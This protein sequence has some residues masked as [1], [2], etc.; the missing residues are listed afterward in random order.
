M[1]SHEGQKKRPSLASRYSS[2]SV[3]FARTQNDELSTS[4]QKHRPQRHVVGQGRLGP[5]V[6]SYGKNVNKLQKLMQQRPLEVNGSPKS[7]QIKRNSSELHRNQEWSSTNLRKNHSETSL[8]KNRSSG[9]LN[10][11]ARPTAAK[12]SMKVSYKRPNRPH[13][14]SSTTIHVPQGPPNPTVRF[15]LGHEEEEEEE[16]GEEEDVDPHED[17]SWTNESAS[18][19]PCTSRSNTRPNSVN[20]SP[21]RSPNSSREVQGENTIKTQSHREDSC[22]PNTPLTL[23]SEASLTIS[24]KRSPR[25]A[26]PSNTNGITT[27][28]L[29]RNSS[30]TIAPQ[31]SNVSSTPVHSDV[32]S[33]QESSRSAGH[34]TLNDNSA[35]EIVSRFLN[36]GSSSGPHTSS[37]LPSHPETPRETSPVG[38][39]D[40]DGPWRNKPSPNITTQ[41]VSRTQR[42]LNLEREAIKNE[43]VN[44]ARP[45]ISILRS[46]HLSN[47]NIAFPAVRGSSDAHLRRLFEQTDI[48]YRR[49]HAFHNP[50]GDAISRLQETG[51][52][53]RARLVQK[54]K[55]GGKQGLL[56]SSTGAGGDGRLGL[57][58]SWRSERSAM[59]G[60]DETGK[61][62]RVSFQGIKG[63]KDD[64]ELEKTSHLEGDDRDKKHKT[65]Q[66]EVRELC[67]RLWTASWEHEQSESTV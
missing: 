46:S 29:N 36:P 21:R 18:Q 64:G 25:R 4:A 17:A 43:P 27:R 14:S 48:E 28:L 16:P 47:V 59:R 62:Q 56:A 19:S 51:T 60:N 49:M 7:S 5:R 24:P 8:K 6:P 32:H 22:S 45:P 63:S 3:S 30:F 54:P 61:K 11:L 38:G 13:R 31:L 20:A 58:Q 42:K 15:A 34:N 53:P 10:K 44:G 50:L 12:A 55:P 37:F 67:E 26:N 66:D 2:G 40:P 65:Q 1:S 57:S 23:H 35:P 52:A 41:Q 9:Q 39:S 33:S